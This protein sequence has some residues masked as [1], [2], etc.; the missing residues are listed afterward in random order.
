MASKRSKKT[1]VTAMMIQERADYDAAKESKFVRRRTGLAAGGGGFA[2]HFRRENDY[3]NLIEK[4]RDMDRNDAIVGTTIGRVV[5]NVVQNGF[6]LN[7]QTGDSKLDN[8]IKQRWYEECEDP[9]AMDVSGEMTFQEQ[10]RIVMR[11]VLLDGDSIISGTEEGPLQIF[12]SHEVGTRNRKEGTHLGVTLDKDTRTRKR[13]WIAKDKVGANHGRGKETSLPLAVR[14]SGGLRQVFHVFDRKRSSMTRGVTS[15]APVFAVT[16]MIDDINFA[17][18]VQQQFVSCFV[19]LR[20]LAAN[21][22]VDDLPNEGFGSDSSEEYT[23]SGKLQAVDDLTPAL[24]LQGRRGEK[25]SGFSPNVPNAEFFQQ[26]RQQISMFGS[27]LNTSPEQVLL[28][29]SMSNFV[30]YRGAINEARKGYRGWQRML[31]KRFHS[32]VYKW[33]LHKWSEDDATLR[34]ALERKRGVA[35]GKFRPFRH[36]WQPPNFEYLEPVNDAAADLLR[37]RNTL[38]SRRRLHAERSQ[39]WYEIADEQV[40]DSR[41]YI[42]RCLQAATDMNSAYPDN[43]MPFTWRDFYSS[44]TSDG[45]QIGIQAGQPPTDASK[46]SSNDE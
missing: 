45:I 16:G 4:A 23:P 39:D 12:E 15:L 29:F 17:K 46:G 35:S 8:D 36:K 22:P 5:D 34:N 18:L 26:F 32:P 1:S 40:E 2:Y 10:E 20:E 38:T 24:E 9:D 13:Y 28:D 37:V 19:L 43:P 31:I 30:G 41:Y 42:E 33:K 7:P 25:L 21:A 27:A 3:Y 14:D 11:Q 44:P 6:T